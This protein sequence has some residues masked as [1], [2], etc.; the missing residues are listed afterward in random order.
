MIAPNTLHDYCEQMRLERGFQK[1]TLVQLRYAIGSFSSWLGRQATADD[2][3]DD[4]FNRWLD[5]LFDSGLS[6]HTIASKRRGALTIW[7][8][9][10][11]AG[12]VRYPQRIRKI[13]IP[14]TNPC[15]WSLK[16]L[17]KLLAAA[18]DV[19]GRF[20]RSRVPRAPLWRAFVLTGYY[21]GLRF[22]DLLDLR[23]E[24]IGADGRVVLTQGKTGNVV[25]CALP[26]EAVEAIDATFPPARER[27]FGNALSRGRIQKR[28]RVLVRSAG[29]KGSS[30]FLRRSG[31]TMSEFVRPGSATAFLGHLT[32]GLAQR[33]YID[34]RLL[35]N[36][37]PIPPSPIAMRPHED[38][39][40]CAVET[41]EIVEAA[42]PTPALAQ[43][44]A[45]AR[46]LA[47]R[48]AGREAAR[49]SLPIQPRSASFLNRHSPQR[50][51]AW[52]IIPAGCTCFPS[53]TFRDT[54]DTRP[55]WRILP[56]QPYP[57]SSQPTVPADRRIP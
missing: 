24:Q 35:Q 55:P 44:M 13:R 32:S 53:S 25:T 3:T 27:I 30:K 12:L 45:L 2:L 26:P 46:K 15:A 48:R 54:S 5:S 6:R 29:L 41:A 1:T 4:V 50:G 33:H 31:A 8:A 14:R 21:S 39:P 56:M 16:E 36:S 19:P 23:R 47:L 37:N 28:F 11:E 49:L 43:R 34:V 52:Q 51:R 57:R 9:L 20:K 40:A 10:H 42:G 22:A 17:A 38:V 7:R 18:E